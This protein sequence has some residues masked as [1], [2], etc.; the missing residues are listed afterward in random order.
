MANPFKRRGLLASSMLATLFGRQ[1]M[2]EQSPISAHKSTIAAEVARVQNTNIVLNRWKPDTCG[3]LL[4]YEWDRNSPPETRVHRA[5]VAGFDK[6]EAGWVRT[7]SVRCELH[8]D[9]ANWQQH[10]EA[11][12]V[13]NRA[14]KAM[15]S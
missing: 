14:A 6:T 1:A 12:L 8:A 9:A 15:I 10:Y 11:V 2:A 13:H 3:C 4:H 7:S 5:G